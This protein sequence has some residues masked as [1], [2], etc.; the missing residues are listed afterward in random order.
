VLVAGAWSYALLRRSPTWHPWIADLVLA[1]AVIAAIAVA[2]GTAV[3]RATVVAAL[4]GSVAVAGGSSAY[5]LDTAATAYRGAVP[6]AGP[7]VGTSGPG[8]GAAFGRRGGTG[9][10]GDSANSALVALVKGATT[11]WAAATIGSQTAG[12]LELASGVAVMSIGGFNGSDAAPT[13]SQFE[14][15]VA[16]GEIHYFISGFG[17]GPVGGGPV[18]GGPGGAGPGGAGPGGRG[19][20]SE[21]STWVAAHFRATTVGGVTVYDLTDPVTAS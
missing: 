21:I 2:A 7:A 6:S 9:P 15:Y 10:T 13:L 16:A 20:G 11:R 4:A 5:A 14:A 8:G 18:G 1:A 12:P 19:T 17:G 3:R